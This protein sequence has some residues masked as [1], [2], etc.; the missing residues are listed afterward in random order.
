MNL[1]D[2]K[3]KV[4]AWFW[5]LGYKLGNTIGNLG[6][7]LV[8]EAFAAGF[9]DT[10]FQTLDMSTLLDNTGRAMDEAIAAMAS[11]ADVDVSDLGTLDFKNVF[12]ELF[13]EKSSHLLATDA[14]DGYAAAH[15]I[16]VA[17]TWIVTYGAYDGTNFTADGIQDGSAGDH[18]KYVNGT[19]EVIV[20]ITR[21]GNV[22][23]AA[24]VVVGK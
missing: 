6:K 12:V 14:A 9:K 18:V 19:E 5:K 1:Q 22:I 13:E 23:S 10:A 3:N 4:I 2:L 16:F 17:Q 7:G 24:T 11:N 8:D 15:A 21:T 20:E